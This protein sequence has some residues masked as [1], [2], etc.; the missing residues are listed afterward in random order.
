MKKFLFA[1][2]FVTAIGLSQAA[3][4]VV[5][6]DEGLYDPLPPEGSA[7]IRFMND[8]GD[9]GSEPAAANGK[10]FDYVEY[11][12][13]SSYFVVP[14]G[15]VD[16]KI[17]ENAGNFDAESGKFYTAILNKDNSVKVTPDAV[18]DNRS[19][20][21]II[22]YNL[23]EKPNLSLK[24]SDGGV[25]IIPPLAA[26]ESSERQI[27]PVKVSLAVYDGDEKVKDLGSLSL[28]RSKSYST[29]VFDE[30]D[31]EWINSTTNTGR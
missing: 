18:N 22:F 13:V 27:N 2:G 26:G 6:A 8:Q 10:T 3:W 20:A 11:K 21:Q 28:E 12:E 23:S 5:N 1:L 7:F 9:T 30:S 29:V 19:K 17:G 16:I 25:E 4:A 31:V 15:K 14:Q 24:T